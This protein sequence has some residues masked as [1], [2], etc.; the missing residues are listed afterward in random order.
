MTLTVIISFS[1]QL[2]NDVGLFLQNHI[3]STKE[4]YNVLLFLPNI[5]II[6]R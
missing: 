5:S 3:Y 6:I 2:Q 4:M 1:Q